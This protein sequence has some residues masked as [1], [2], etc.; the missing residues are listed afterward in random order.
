MGLKDPVVVGLVALG[1]LGACDDSG[2]TEAGRRPDAV[3][4]PNGSRDLDAS[5]P[6]RDLDAATDAATETVDAGSVSEPPTEPACRALSSACPFLRCEDV[7]STL[8]TASR[9]CG[10]PPFISSVTQGSACARTIVAYRY[11]A[12]DTTIAFFDV[13]TGVLTGWWNQSDTGSIDCSGDV[14]L[15]C[16]MST[17]TSLSRAGGCEEDAGAAGANDAGAV[18]SGS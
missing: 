5:T 11:G 7:A 12:G 14:D 13:E 2:P 3:T 17:A 15:D 1:V 10:T 4:P 16:A 8:S 6:E 9:R 18:D